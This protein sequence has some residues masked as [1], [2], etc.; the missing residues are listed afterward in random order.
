[1]GPLISK[2]TSGGGTHTGKITGKVIV[3]SNLVDTDANPWPGDWYRARVKEALGGRY[4]DD[5]RLWYN[6]NADHLEGPVTGARAARHVEFTGILQ[7]ALRELI[8]WVEKGVK[9]ARTTSYDVTGS[10]ISVPEHAANRRGIQ[11]VVDLTVDGTDRIEV[12]AGTPVTFKA[13]I[14]VPPGAG[15]VV[16]TE[17]DFAGT[18]DFA[19]KPFGP[20]RT[21]V[22]IR[23][24]F[25][26]T[27]PGTYFP[28]L[29]ATAQREGDTATPFAQVGNIG[30]ARVVVR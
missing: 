15:R 11:P 17:W 1:M 3:V 14:E 12:R 29:R 16:H 20:P 24:T 10:Q 19:A 7:Q 21:T 2:S 8:A 18:G 27:E 26:Y 22:E 28:V 4:E 23:Q 13:H 9:P 25:T 30:R 5:F 6:D